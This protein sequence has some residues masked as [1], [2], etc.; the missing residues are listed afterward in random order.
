MTDH[1]T[2][3]ARLPRL[4]AG[5][6]LGLLA[7]TAV[8][9]LAPRRWEAGGAVLLR[10]QQPSMPSIPGSAM[11]AGLAANSLTGLAGMSS[12]AALET[13]TQV[14][15]SRVLLGDVVDSLRLQLVP[16]ADPVVLPR[17][18]ATDVALRGRFK[19][20]KLSFEREGNGWR[21]SGKTVDTT[22]AAGGTLRLPEG[23]ITFASRLP[24]EFTLRVYDRTEAVERLL[25][26]A[27]V[28]K[29]KGTVLRLG[30]SAADS[31]SAALI[32]NTILAFYLRQRETVDRGVNRRRADFLQAQL[33][34]VSTSLGQAEGELRRYQ[35]TSGVLDPVETGRVALEATLPI[36]EQ[37]GQVRVEEAALARLLGEVRSGSADARTLSAYPAFL[38]STGVNELLADLTRLETERTRLLERRT[39]EDPEVVAIT[40]SITNLERQLLPLAETYG[41]SLGRQ[42]AE[43]E[44]QLRRA[45]GSLAALPGAAE[46][47]AARQRSALQLGQSW[48]GLQMQLQAARIAAIGEGADARVLD[49]A[50]VPVKAAFPK[51]VVVFPLLTL[52]GALA[53]FL[54][55]VA[56][57]RL[58]RRVTSSAEAERVAGVPAVRFDPSAPLLVGALG[59]TRGLLVVALDERADAPA[60]ARRLVASL[61]GRGGVPARLAA[62]NGGGAADVRR[63]LVE[64]PGDVVVT[65]LPRFDD[66][67]TASLLDR[68]HAV[69]LVGTLGTLERERLRHAT[70]VLERLDVPCAGL[71]LHDGGRLAPRG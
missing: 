38:R 56:R 54:L 33:D 53:A 14:M 12:T 48:A 37:L 60:V 15:T 36:R 71:V 69:L 28:E 24:D 55:P 44:G 34:S 64:R 52:L 2:L 45:E 19:R 51:P 35:E 47:Y 59:A 31:I 18:L 21:V 7:A 61:D 11:P 10:L 63:T 58:G 17:D 25:E 4:A 29:P 32:P 65:A 57:Q 41:T 16:R 70:Q 3:R 62:M 46:G 1:T 50:D 22:I 43:L 9:F 13:E 20:K 66:D 6:T 8:H 40:Q 49:L 67:A 30:A 5:A 68:D 23:T 27:T 26:R 42:R 39:E